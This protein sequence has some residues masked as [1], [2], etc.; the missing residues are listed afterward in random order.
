M[1]KKTSYLINF[2]QKILK[3]TIK[4]HLEQKIFFGSSMATPWIKMAKVFLFNVERICKVKVPELELLKFKVN[5][6]PIK[7]NL[8]CA[9]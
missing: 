7:L 6:F 1:L 2:S 5:P 3:E 8:N 9:N 4:K